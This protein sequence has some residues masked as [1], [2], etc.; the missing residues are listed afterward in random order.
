MALGVA[1]GTHRGLFSHVG[2]TF[3]VSCP[4][5]GAE[6]TADGMLEDAV[7]CIPVDNCR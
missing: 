6:Q 3:S 7:S 4:L 1:P 2:P 5:W